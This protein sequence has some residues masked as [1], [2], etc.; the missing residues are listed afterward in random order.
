MISDYQGID[1]FTKIK[2]KDPFCQNC[3]LKVFCQVIFYIRKEALIEL[4]AQ[5]QKRQDCPMGINCKQMISMPRNTIISVRKR[6][7][8]IN[9]MGFAPL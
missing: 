2:D 5:Y 1:S 3:S 8:T 6:N 4:H 9:T 7:L